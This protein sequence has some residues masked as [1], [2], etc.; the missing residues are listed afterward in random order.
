MIRCRWGIVSLPM[1]LSP[2][3]PRGCCMSSLHSRKRARVSTSIPTMRPASDQL[4]IMRGAL[5]AKAS[6]PD[7]AS[8]RAELKALALATAFVIDSAMLV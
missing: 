8:N 6:Q 4:Q 2:H 1:I 3:M 5:I 7:S